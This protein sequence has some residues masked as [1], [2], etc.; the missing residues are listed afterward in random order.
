MEVELFAIRCGI[1][2]ACIKENVSKII[3]ITNSIHAVKRVFDSKLHPFQ[4]H[5]MAILSELRHFLTKITKIPLNFGNALVALNG[6]FTRTSIKIPSC[7]IPSSLT[8][9]KYLGITARNLIAMT[10]STNGK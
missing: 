10:L 3:I 8:L 6:D 1:N 5:T 4:S 7:S 9:A 2:Q